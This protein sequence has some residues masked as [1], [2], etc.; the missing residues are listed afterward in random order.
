M[1]RVVVSPSA[2]AG[3]GAKISSDCPCLNFVSA[4]FAGGSRGRPA[5]CRIDNPVSASK[6][7]RRARNF[8]PSVVITVRSGSTRGRIKANGWVVAARA[9][10]SGSPRSNSATSIS[11][12]ACGKRAAIVLPSSMAHP[13]MMLAWAS[14]V[15]VSGSIF[16]TM[17]L[18][19]FCRSSKRRIF[20]PLK[21]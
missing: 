5:T 20:T 19:P 2:A 6:P 7:I 17:P 16:S 15:S 11:A 13:A 12:A 8:L 3:S 10:I 4:S 14:F 21:R 18:S 1:L 9:F